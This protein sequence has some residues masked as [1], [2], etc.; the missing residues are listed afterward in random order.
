MSNPMAP[1]QL[2]RAI[3]ATSPVES[4]IDAS[5][6]ASEWALQLRDSRRLVVPSILVAHLSSNPFFALS[7]DFLEAGKCLSIDLGVLSSDE[8]T[9]DGEFDRDSSLEISK[10][11]QGGVVGDE[12]DWDEDAMWVKPLAIS[13]PDAE[14]RIE[15]KGILGAHE[16]STREL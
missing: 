11:E 12:G 7:S 4:A 9:E 16:K 2:D 8:W 10:F 1:K 15:E 6:N 13:L 3:V 5:S 14:V